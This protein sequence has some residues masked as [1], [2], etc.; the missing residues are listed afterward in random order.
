MGGRSNI[1]VVL[2]F[3]PCVGYAH[4]EWVHQYQVKQAYLLLSNQI[5]RDIPVMSQ[6]I[7]LNVEGPG[8]LRWRTRSIVGGAWREDL[9]DVVWG[10]ERPTLQNPVPC[11]WDPSST[12][13]WNADAGDNSTINVPDDGC[14]GIGNAYQKALRLLWPA[15]YGMWHVYYQTDQPQQWSFPNPN[16]GNYTI[17]N[18]YETTSAI[19]IEYNSLVDFYRTGTARI[20]GYVA[21]DGSWVTS[22]TDYRLPIAVHIGAPLK[23]DIIWEALGRV[24]H[25]L[26]DMSVPAHALNDI[27][28]CYSSI[29]PNRT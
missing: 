1:F 7:G 28:P 24:A 6:F 26:G 2:I 10:H 29:R 4:K 8:S 19:G 3:V 11:G 17:P 21:I 18:L 25:L 16:G 22:A 9:E 23:D 15:T 5:G 13:F 12:H 14:E 27:H 20:V